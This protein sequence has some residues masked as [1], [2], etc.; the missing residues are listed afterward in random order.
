MKNPTVVSCKAD[1][2]KSKTLGST[3][4]V[5][6]NDYVGFAPSGRETRHRGRSP[7]ATKSCSR[8]N[9][10]RGH[11]L[12]RNAY[13]PSTGDVSGRPDRYPRTKIKN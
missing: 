2:V 6:T 4:R 11:A 8:S 1:E 7:L 9:D 10:F 5:I 12:A 3:G 13:Y